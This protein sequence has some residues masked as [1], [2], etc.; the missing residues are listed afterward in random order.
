MTLVEKDYSKCR[1]DS[2]G[3]HDPENRN[4]GG[5]D[6]RTS[7]VY[8]TEKL[9]YRFEYPSRWNYGNCVFTPNEGIIQK[10]TIR[11]DHSCNPYSA[12]VSHPFFKTTSSD[13][14][15]KPPCIHTMP[16]TYHPRNHKYWE[17]LASVGMYRTRGFN[18]SID[19]S[20]I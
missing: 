8:K 12:K 9:P 18:T 1:L 10:Y 6:I 19:K 11:A 17:H 14:G 4:F 2:N 15:S 3:L 7:D 5:E 13:Y 20:P 16:H